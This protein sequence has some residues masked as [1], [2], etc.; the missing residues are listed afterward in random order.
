MAINMQV[1]KFIRDNPF[2]RN[3]AMVNTTLVTL[4]QSETNDLSRLKLLEALFKNNARL[5]WLVYR[6]Y[7]YNQSLSSVMGFVYEG[8][9]KSADS[10][11][12]DS[13]VP[14]YYYA[15]QNI[16]GILQNWYNYNNDIIHVPVAKRKELSMEILDVS[17]MMESSIFMVDGTDSESE[18]TLSIDLDDLIVEYT[19]RYPLTEKEQLEMDMLILARSN[20]YKEVAIEFNVTV[21]KARRTVRKILNKLKAFHKRT[22]RD[23]NRKIK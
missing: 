15:L 9:V 12:S 10:F 20:T 16:R 2:P 4:I 23:G 1:E 11:K 14:F 7:N 8:L 17:D 3:G 22:L 18:D 19:R 21:L 5:I 13:G 6:Q